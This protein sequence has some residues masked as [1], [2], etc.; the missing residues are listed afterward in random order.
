MVQPWRSTLPE[1][2]SGC[3]W[4]RVV[5]DVDTGVL[6]FLIREHFSRCRGFLPSRGILLIE[7]LPTM[8]QQL[9]TNCLLWASIEQFLSSRISLGVAG[10]TGCVRPVINVMLILVS[11]VKQ[12]LCGVN[13]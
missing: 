1:L 4:A 12:S 2:M 9:L 11:L 3:V 6:F 10:G 5:P 13:I 7:F 8:W